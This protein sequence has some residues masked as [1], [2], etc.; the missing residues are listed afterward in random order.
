MGRVIF[1]FLLLGFAGC[2][3]REQAAGDAVMRT[4]GRTHPSAKE[5]Q[6]KIVGTWSLNQG[7]PNGTTDII[8]V[9]FRADGD[10]LSTRNFIDPREPRHGDQP[11]SARWR[12]TDGCF[13]VAN[14]NSFPLTVG[15]IFFVDRIDENGMVCHH[16]SV[17]ERVVF[18]R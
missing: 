4:S 7:T 10:F 11:Y 17:A 13:V 9:T 14:S 3:T 6:E 8:K 15:Q 18:K 1:I 16:A 2:A 12:A 5:I